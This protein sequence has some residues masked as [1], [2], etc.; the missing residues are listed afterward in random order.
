MHYS[1]VD[2]LIKTDS[3][4]ATHML[5]NGSWPICWPVGLAAQPANLTKFHAAGSAQMVG[6]IVV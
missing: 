2:K 3:S 5:H 6:G 1:I 4:L